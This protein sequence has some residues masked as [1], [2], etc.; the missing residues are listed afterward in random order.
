MKPVTSTMVALAAGV[1]QAT[2][3]RVL[4]DSPRVDAD[5]RERVIR[6]AR[7]LKYP[8]IPQS[9][10]RTAGV[11]VTR[12]TPINS[13]YAMTLSAIKEAARERHYRLE[14]ISNQDIGM[15]NTRIINGAIAF[16]ND[17]TLNR[18]WSE[19]TTLP[20][21]RYE[22]KSSHG[23]NIY[24]V[25]TDLLPLIAEAFAHL[26]Q[27]GHREIAVLFGTSEKGYGN[28]LVPP[29]PYFLRELGRAGVADPESRL[30]FSGG[31]PVDDWLRRML[32]EGCTAL[33][34]FPGELA[35][36]VCGKL[37]KMGCRVPDDVSIVSREFG[38][39]SEFWSPPLTTI[40]PDFSRVG[41]VVL[42]LLDRLIDGETDLTDIPIPG[43]YIIRESV[44]PARR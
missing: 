41:H 35:M 44:A 6:A 30:F 4:N 24:T 25:Y 34:I 3:S 32:S 11:I 31:G 13:F 29:M 18:R 10:T 17:L 9:K 26:R 36:Q 19:T 40:C 1:S 33:V 2:V 5:T 8:L 42:E 23:D 15:L 14:I 21:V 43:T 37:N 27:N 22:S 39:I 12:E 28:H 38:G 16:S 20:L 7:E